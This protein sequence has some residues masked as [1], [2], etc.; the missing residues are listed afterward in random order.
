[1]PIAPTLHNY[2]AAENI[3]YDE[4]QHVLTTSSARTAQ[5]CH[6]PGDRLRIV[7]HDCVTF[8]REA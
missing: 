3:Q 6:V 4:I 7:A 8:T 2:L 5:A 1:M